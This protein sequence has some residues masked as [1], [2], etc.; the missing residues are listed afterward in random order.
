MKLVAI[1]DFFFQIEKFGIKEDYK[2]ILKILIYLLHEI[3]HIKMFSSKPDF[4]YRTP[5]KYDY[6]E[7]QKSDFLKTYGIE[8][9]AG[10]LVEEEIMEVKY[11]LFRAID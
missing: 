5:K 9:E 8:G 7:D 4:T 10:F 3:A 2:S 1:N 6:S 11:S